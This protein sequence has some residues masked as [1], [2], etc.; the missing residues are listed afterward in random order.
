MSTT[1]AEAETPETT[2]GDGP[3][4]DLTDAAVKKF[5]KQAK[6]RG[7]VTM[8]ELNK[9]LPS[10]EVTSEAIEDTL[11]MLSEMGVNVVEAEEDAEGGGEVAVREESAVVETAKEAAYDRT[12]DPVRMY[13]R[14]MGSVELLSREGEIAIAKRIEAGRDTMIRGLCESALTFEAIMVW[15]EEL[16]SGRI[17]LREVIDLEQTYGGLNAGVEA[18]PVEAVA[19]AEEEK[20]EA[21][22]VEGQPE[23]ESDDDFDDGAGPTISAMEAEL[24]EGVM[25]TLDAIAVEFEAFRLLQEKLVGQRLKG[26]DLS[27]KDRAAYQVAT[28]AIVQHLKTLKLNNNRIE[29]L[30]EQLYAINKRLM[31]LEG[32]LLR[33]A[34]SYGISRSEFLKAYF[35]SELRPDWTDQVKALGIRWTK[36]AEND[37]GQIGDIRHEIAALATETGVPI[38]DY[39]RIVQT[40]QKGEREARQAKKEMVE[41]NLRLVISIAKKYTNRGLQFLDLIQEGNIG[42]MKAVDKFEYRRGYKFS[43]YATWW[44]RQAITRSIADQARTIRIPVHMIET[45]NKIVRTSRQMLHEIGREPTPEELAEKLAMPLEKVRKVLKIAKE[46]ISLETPIGDEE[47]SHLGDFIEDKNA[48]L[49]IDAAIQS[50]LRETTT[51]VLAS[52]TPREE[53]VLR[54]R[55]GIGMN[56]D[57]TLEEVGQQFSVTRERIRQIEAKA[58]RKLKHPSRSRKLRSFLD[59]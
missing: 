28:G 9:V 14:E 33:L 29:A 5:I 18:L 47:D 51:R 2:S 11:A 53:R 19:E 16:G 34:D 56:T 40:V 4:L 55:F 30:V 3:L 17:L 24:R 6:A 50:N 12:D 35:G 15:R 44:I 13:L 57:H 7:Y 22:A 43:T 31:G 54:M 48:I 21:E 58:L 49:P 41:A 26:E 8:D 37:N 38:D 20:E 45:I 23:G 25:A 39:R 42:L 10:E 1:T 36:F 52:L 59:S 46:P 32:R 27:D